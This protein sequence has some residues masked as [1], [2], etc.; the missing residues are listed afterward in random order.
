LVH[1]FVHSLSI[2]RVNLSCHFFNSFSLD[3]NVLVKLFSLVVSLFILR[4]H[5]LL[6]Y[7]HFFRFI[8]LPLQLG[9]FIE[10]LVLL[11]EPSTFSFQNLEF[12]SGDGYECEVDG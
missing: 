11:D 6:L 3:L 12:D 9:L 5:S 10:L 7:F 4:L 8:S 1:S 2:R